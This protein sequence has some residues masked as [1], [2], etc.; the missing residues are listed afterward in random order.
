MLQC[1]AFTLCATTLDIK[2]DLVFIPMKKTTK[3]GYEATVV[4]CNVHSTCMLPHSWAFV[5]LERL[6]HVK[7]LHGLCHKRIF[8]TENGLCFK[9]RKAGAWE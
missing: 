6:V 8:W 1:A 7:L 9:K 5:L 3:L 4:T 2:I